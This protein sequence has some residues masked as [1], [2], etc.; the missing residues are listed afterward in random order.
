M[1]VLFMKMCF[2]TQQPGF[3]TLPLDNRVTPI[4]LYYYLFR[5]LIYKLDL[6]FEC[7]LLAE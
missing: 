5:F 6:L 7:S 4:L 2:I 3:N 1:Y